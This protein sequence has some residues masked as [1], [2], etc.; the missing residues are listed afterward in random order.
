[1]SLAKQIQPLYLVTE[2]ENHTTYSVVLSG[3][4]ST[5]YW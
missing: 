5:P 3:E 4:G 1:M 2:L